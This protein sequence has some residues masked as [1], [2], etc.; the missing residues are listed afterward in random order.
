MIFAWYGHLK[1]KD[2]PLDAIN[3][4]KVFKA[5]NGLMEFIS[6]GSPPIN[7]VLPSVDQR[8]KPE[9]ASWERY[10]IKIIFVFYC[11]PRFLFMS[12]S[13]L[14]YSNISNYHET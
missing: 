7:N 8:M 12:N 5:P 10:M 14:W 13:T 1:Y 6:R 4:G 11:Y 3:V 9:K 2:A